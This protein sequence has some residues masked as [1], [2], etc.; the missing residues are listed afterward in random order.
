MAGNDIARVYATS[1]VEI[2]QTK[3][4]LSQLEEE[5]KFVADCVTED[6]DLQLFLNSPGFPKESKAKFIKSVFSGKLSDYMVNFLL[7]LI[8]NDR[9]N[10]ISEIYQ[11]VVQQ[12]DT[13][14]N[15]QRVTVIS[16]SGLDDKT[17]DRISTVLNNKLKKE[18][19]LK[20]EVKD[21]IL[22]GI[23]IK[24]DDVVIDGSLAKD[25]KKIRTNLLNSKVRSEVAYED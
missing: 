16:R 17:L 5:L 10:L 15:R 8:Q 3:N 18:I 19:I 25:L 20:E 24:I 9:Q 2:G 22:G 13:V 4:N 1:L 21:G 6:K 7:V 23:I 14:N 12:I 11:E